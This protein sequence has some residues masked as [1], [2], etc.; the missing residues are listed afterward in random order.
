[1][2]NITISIITVVKNGL[3]FLKEAIKSFDNQTLKSKEHIIVYAPSNDGTEELLKK[4]NNKIIIKDTKSRNKF[5]AINIGIKHCKGE[6]VGIL[7]A[8]DFY[9]DKFT[10]SRVYDFYKQNISDLIYG[11][12]KICHKKKVNKIIRYWKS[13][14]FQ[15]KKIQY[16]WMP[17]HTSVFIKRNIISKN[18]YKLNYPISGDYEFIL[19]IFK[20]KNLKINFFDSTLCIMR[21]GGDSTKFKN[22]I[23]KIR[24][25]I[26]ISKEFFSNYY[27]CVIFKIL[28]KLN[29]FFI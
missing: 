25:D 17:P 10:L 16:G 7:H 27:M 23:K 28:R 22:I 8:D 4:I 12:I 5:G 26:K 24:E 20:K 19:R 9:P 29:Q 11:N 14:P 15:M 6:L 13:E 2:K 18:L 21:T 1:M 3:P